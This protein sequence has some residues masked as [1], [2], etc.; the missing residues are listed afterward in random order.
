MSTMQSFPSIVDWEHR[1]TP[2]M[3]QCHN[4]HH[5]TSVIYCSYFIDLVGNVFT[6]HVLE[7]A[8]NDTSSDLSATC[9]R[10]VSD[11]VVVTLTT[12]KLLTRCVCSHFRWT[13]RTS[14]LHVYT[15]LHTCFNSNSALHS[16]LI[17]V[18]N[19]NNRS[20]TLASHRV[21][22]NESFSSIR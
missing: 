21:N 17:L 13:N 8:P 20:Y 4:R 9:R 11:I 10:H 2:N 12:H 19:Q 7:G 5:F 18:Y 6:R 14:Y 3:K 15:S 22:C 1:L 16:I